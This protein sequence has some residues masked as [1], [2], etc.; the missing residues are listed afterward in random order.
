MNQIARESKTGSIEIVSL[1]LCRCLDCQVV[2][3]GLISVCHVCEAFTCPDC[4]S[5]EIEVG[6]SLRSIF[7]A[8]DFT[9][10]VT[11]EDLEALNERIAPGKLF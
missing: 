9:S 5:E 4:R 8:F 2:F 6:L 3:N 11:D 10:T 1:E 7:P